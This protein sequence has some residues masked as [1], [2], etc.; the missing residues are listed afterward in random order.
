MGPPSLCLD[1]PGEPCRFSPCEPR[2]LPF[3]PAHLSELGASARRW[4][5]STSR[6]LWEAS[7][8]PLSL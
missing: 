3:P 1:L 8:E 5:P 6:P 2:G 7:S 4:G